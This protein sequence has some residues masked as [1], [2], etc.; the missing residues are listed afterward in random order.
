MEKFNTAMT[1][2]IGLPQLRGAVSVVEIT[3]VSCFLFPLGQACEQAWKQQ[4]R[5]VGLEPVLHAQVAN[6]QVAEPTMFGIAEENPCGFQYKPGEVQPPRIVEG[7][8][9]TV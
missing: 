5:S 8:K 1:F 2:P 6:V 3:D 7:M 4:G 9:I